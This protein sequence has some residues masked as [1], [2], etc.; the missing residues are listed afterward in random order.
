MHRAGQAGV[1]AAGDERRVG[2]VQDHRTSHVKRCDDFITWHE[3]APVLPISVL[4]QQPKNKHK[5]LPTRYI[6]SRLI[7]HNKSDKLPAA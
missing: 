2:A 5:Y 6:F 7:E 4:R 1:E 3:A